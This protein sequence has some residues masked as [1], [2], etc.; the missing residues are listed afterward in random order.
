MERMCGGRQIPDT[1]LRRGQDLLT[2]WRWSVRGK[3]VKMTIQLAGFPSMKTGK[4][5]KNETGG[6]HELLWSCR[7]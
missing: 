6:N 4:P 5:G 3:R 2:D 7:A 1:F